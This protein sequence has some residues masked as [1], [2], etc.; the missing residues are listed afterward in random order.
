MPED[1][2]RILTESFLKSSWPCVTT[3]VEKLAVF[4]EEN[5]IRTV[6]FFKFEN[7]KRINQ[8]FAG[9]HFFLRGSVEYTNPQLTVE[10]VQ[11]VIGTRML[12]VS[13]NYFSDH[14]LH[15]PNQT[16]VANISELLKKPS[17]G[18][19]IAFLLNTDDVEPDR[20][21]MNPLKSSIVSSGQSAFPSANV[22]AENLKIDQ[23][24]TEKYDGT[25]ISRSETE[26]V[27][28]H[29]E[30]SNGSYMDFIDSVKYAQLGSL[31]NVFGINLSLNSLRMPLTTLRAETK[32]G[33]LHHIISETHRDFNS[34]KQAYDCMGRS[35]T[36]RTTL[37]TIPHSKKGFGSKR[38]ARGRLHFDNTKFKDA[39]IRYQPTKLYPNAMDMENPSMAV[40]EDNFEIPGDQ[41][42]DYSFEETP[43]S[44]QFFLYSLASPEDAA[45][46]HGVGA[47][48][49]PQLLGSYTSV[50]NVCRKGEFIQN[51]GAKFGVRL[52]VPLQFNLSP[53]GMWVHPIHRNIDASMGCVENPADLAQ[54]GMQLEFLSAFK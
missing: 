52:E 10:E 51:L 15:I 28:Q 53:N 31:S 1:L 39:T 42:A 12:E 46:W 24:F 22:K 5:L 23:D 34:L 11:G 3:L 20:Y 19:L 41:L 30:N 49:A 6:S 48:A 54:M 35:M 36:K 8:T 18:L 25:L 37:M 44:P 4:K 43:S 32:N 16:D 45:M 47:F 7:G 21:S 27:K 17:Q 9:N 38:A 2:C 33:L 50:R 29:L 26:L 14:G 13:G 40:A